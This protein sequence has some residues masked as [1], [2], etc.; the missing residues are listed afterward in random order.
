MDMH[1][2]I[3]KRFQGPPEMGNGGYV[4]GLLAKGIEGPAQVTL[5][6]PTPLERRLSKNASPSGGFLLT[7]GDR[8]IAEAHGR[9]LDLQA[10]DMPTVAQVAVACAGYVRPDE[11]PFPRCFV[12]GPDRSPPDGLRIVAAPVPNRDIVAATWVPDASLVDESGHVAP[13]FMW[14]VLDCPGATAV[15]RRHPGAILLGTMTASIERRVA[16]GE[17]CVVIGWELKAEGRKHF[18]GTALYS[19]SLGLCGRASAVWIEP[20][21]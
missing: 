21:E 16:L 11:H 9:S 15:A 10:P 2:T 6:A 8:I 17:Q 14:A 5:M 7:D 18:T 13:E 12:C 3:A 1:I 4:G 19:E 20:R